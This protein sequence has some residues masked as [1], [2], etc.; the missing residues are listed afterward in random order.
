MYKVGL[1][2]GVASLEEDNICVVVFYHLSAS[3]IWHYKRVDLW[4]EELY[5]R[6]T[7]VI[8]ILKIMENTLVFEN[9]AWSYDFLFFSPWKSGLLH[10]YLWLKTQFFFVIISLQ[11]NKDLLYL[12]SLLI[13]IYKCLI[14]INYFLLFELCIYKMYKWRCFNGNKRRGSFT[15]TGLS[16][17]G[18]RTSTTCLKK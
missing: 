5:K 10:Q 14:K 1:T 4:W 3:E 7:T 6:G 17:T 12:S 11:F 9:Y 18:T 2:G 15:A 16:G 13:L 8:N